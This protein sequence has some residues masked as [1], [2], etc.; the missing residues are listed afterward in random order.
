MHLF[1]LN[2]PWYSIRFKLVISLFA[3]MVPLIAMLFY[4]GF[5]T[6]DV[7]YAQV[8]KTNHDLLSLY[9]SQID[10]D[11]QTV[12]DYLQ[13]ILTADENVQ[14][15]N[16]TNNPNTL[17]LAKN[18]LF[19]RI[20]NDILSYKSMDCLFFYIP[21]NQDFVYNF[22]S[23]SSLA[24]RSQVKEHLIEQLNAQD[25]SALSIPDQWYV[26]RIGSEHYM[27]RIVKSD[28]L[29]VGAWL[30]TRKLLKP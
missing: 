18:R 1:K 16:S 21:E 19:R 23:G 26:T 17:Q 15:I 9:T 7:L 30:N 24:E 20:S 12:D 25:A 14:I 6:V 22:V 27:F 28:N 4:N 8:A 13:N 3:F 11:L 5:Y 10:S 29:I 2:I